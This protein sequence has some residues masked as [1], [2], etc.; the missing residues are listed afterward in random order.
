MTWIFATAGLV[1]AGLFSSVFAA[2]LCFEGGKEWGKGKSDRTLFVLFCV[3]AVGSAIFMFC[4]GRASASERVDVALVLA[5]DVSRSMSPERLQIQRN[6]YAAAIRDDGGVVLSA[7]RHGRRGRIAIAYFEWAGDIE[8]WD[9][10]PWTVIETAGDLQ[11]AA[12]RI[13]TAPINR[14]SSTSISAAMD[15]S[16]VLLATAPP[17]ERHVVDIS[18]DGI[19]NGMGAVSIARGKLLDSGATINGLPI[20]PSDDARL[21]AYYDQCVVGGPGAFMFPVDGPDQIEHGLRAKL[22]VEISG[23]TPP[24][25]IMPAAMMECD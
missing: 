24:A 6:G 8:M 16:K 1:A 12:D 7:I 15:R 20:F 4:A 14:G 25:R 17:A 22:V 23:L 11:A 10:L 19:H 13:A 3:F 21:D 2:A 9:V 5:A 18:G